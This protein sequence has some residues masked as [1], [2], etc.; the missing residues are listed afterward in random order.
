[1]TRKYVISLGLAAGL[2]LLLN[3]LQKTTC[4]D[5]FFRQGLPFAYFN[6]GGYVGGGGY[7]WLGV[8]GNFLV[9]VVT[10]ISLGWM[11]TRIAGRIPR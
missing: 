6:E 11:W 9:V 1:M 10:G 8:V 5:C 4:S 2:F 3:S 7:I